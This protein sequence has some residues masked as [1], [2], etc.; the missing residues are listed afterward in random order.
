MHL[1]RIQLTEF[2][3]Y[4]ALDLAVPPTGLVAV[5][6]NAA[7]KSSLLEAVRMLSTLRSLTRN[8]L[9]TEK[10]A[11]LGQTYLHQ[12]RGFNRPSASTAKNSTIE[13][14]CPAV[15]GGTSS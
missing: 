10:T 3:S 13:T 8:R 5:G 12:N 11:P 2:R 15:T 7:G 6:Q 4:H 1:R 9:P 14:I